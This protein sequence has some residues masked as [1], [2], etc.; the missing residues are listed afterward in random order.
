MKKQCP[1][2]EV[3]ADYME[4]RLSDEDMLALDAHFS[5]CDAC[6]E[7]LVIGKSVARNMEQ[8][9]PESVPHSLTISAM[10]LVDDLNTPLTEKCRNKIFALRRFPK[11]ICSKISDFLAPDFWSSQNIS[12][13]FRGSYESVSDNCEPVIKSFSGIKTKIE[14]EKSLNDHENVNIRVSILSEQTVIFEDIRVSLKKEDRELSS[15]LLNNGYTLFENIPT[16]E[17]QLVFTKEGVNIGEY[18]FQLGIKN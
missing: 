3:F 5:D 1:D 10:R 9:E 15:F 14:I 6:L 2:D 4:G 8:S 13:V 16:G 18:I 7:N 12:P 11:K 17:Y